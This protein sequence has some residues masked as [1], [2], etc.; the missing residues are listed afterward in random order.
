MVGLDPITGVLIR[1]D[2][3]TDTQRKDHIERVA[4]HKPRGEASK[5]TDPA[6]TLIS[7]FW[8]PQL[9]DDGF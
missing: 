1:G 6:T 2:Q 8:S 3:D 5:G 4:T 9:W 7:D